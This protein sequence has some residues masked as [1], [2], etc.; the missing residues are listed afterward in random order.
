ML[1][2]RVLEAGRGAMRRITHTRTRRT[3]TCTHTHRQTH[4]RTHTLPLT[5]A[6]NTHRDKATLTD[7]VGNK[8]LC[9]K[10]VSCK[11]MQV[12][13]R[14]C[15]HLVQMVLHSHRET[16]LRTHAT[17]CVFTNSNNEMYSIC[18]LLGS[19][20][21][22]QEHIST[23]SSVVVCWRGSVIAW[24]RGSVCLCP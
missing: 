7:T 16:T 21:W 6:P 14:P 9:T 3:H 22:L 15:R 5:L 23:L 20:T 24:Q 17:V 13:T 2:D 12:R 1:T 19:Q 11:H 10:T 18:T 8:R 4:A